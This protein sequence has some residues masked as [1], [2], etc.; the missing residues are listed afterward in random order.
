MRNI[1]PFKSND[2]IEENIFWV[3]MSDL[4]LGFLITFIVLFV[5]VITGFSINNL[6]E[7][8]EAQ[9]VMENIGESLNKSKIKLDID[10]LNNTVKVSDLELFEI[11]SSELTEKGKEFLNKFIPIYFDNL[12]KDKEIKEKIS[13]IMIV[14]HTDS[15]QFKYARS[16]EE[17]FNLNLDLSSKRALNVAKYI[18]SINK[19]PEIS[20]ELEKKITVAGR[21]YSEPILVNNK[22]DYSKS[23]RVEF[24][25][26]YKAIKLLPKE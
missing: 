7:Q 19:D 24:K 17:N 25:I 26:V 16:K 9:E 1:L 21:S 6:N 12:F 4:L 13:Q 11:N 10:K 8:Q 14:G 22:E 23:R 20:K 2:E 3:T 18:I 15:Q 5:L